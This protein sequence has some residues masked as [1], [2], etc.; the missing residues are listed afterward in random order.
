MRCVLV[1]SIPKRP[2]SSVPLTGD[3]QTDSDI[4]AFIRARESILQKKC[5]WGS[6]SSATGPGLLLCLS[7][8]EGGQGTAAAGQRAAGL[9]VATSRGQG[10]SPRF[11]WGRGQTGQDR[12]SRLVA[13]VFLPH[14]AEQTSICSCRLPPKS[15]STQER[16]A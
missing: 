7:V 15:L 11:P 3:S 1:P 9:A 2:A 8:P 16:A 5:K 4:L 12:S 13:R 10:L 6:H 14:S